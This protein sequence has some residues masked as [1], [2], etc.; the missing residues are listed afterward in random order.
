MGWSEFEMKLNNAKLKTIPLGKSVCDGNNLYFTTTGPER[1]K[2][3][4]RYQRLGKKREMGL[5]P[6]PIISL[7]EA[8]QRASPPLP[9]NQPFCGL[10]YIG[11]PAFMSDAT[12]SQMPQR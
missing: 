11:L 4:F 6:Y 3:S 1:G 8:R 5:G 10:P 9:S 2:W 7:A 12:T